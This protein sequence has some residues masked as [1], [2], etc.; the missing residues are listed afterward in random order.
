MNLYIE[1]GTINIYKLLIN[2]LNMNDCKIAIVP[3]DDYLLEFI[4]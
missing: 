3:S 1:V 2:L 4:L